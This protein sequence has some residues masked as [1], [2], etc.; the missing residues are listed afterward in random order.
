MMEAGRFNRLT[1]EARADI[2]CQKGQFVDSVILKHYCLMLYNV[3]DTFIELSLDLKSQNIVWIS[4][5][6]E[7]DLSKYLRDVQIEV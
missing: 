6:N 5:A 2:V 1:L 3:H 7:H 4:I